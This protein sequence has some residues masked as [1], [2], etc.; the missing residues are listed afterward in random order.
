VITVVAGFSDSL[1]N[2]LLL[3][4]GDNWPAKELA[5]PNDTRIATTHLIVLFENFN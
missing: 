5:A 4:S 2:A 3:G 1:I